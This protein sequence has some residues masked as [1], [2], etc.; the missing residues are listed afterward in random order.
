LNVLAERLYF[1]PR[2]VGMFKG[3]GVLDLALGFGVPL[4]RPRTRGST[5]SRFF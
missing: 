2:G 5:S 1:G 3:Y 4:W